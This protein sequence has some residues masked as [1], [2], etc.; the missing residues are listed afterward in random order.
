MAAW[1]RAHCLREWV[2]F[3]CKVVTD[4]VAEAR[5][6][7]KAARPDAGLGIY[8][9]PDVDGLSEPLTGQRLA[10]LAP[11]ADWLSPMLY[12]NILLRPPGWIGGALMPALSVVGG[13]TLPVV[14][15]DSNRDPTAVGDWGPEMSVDDWRA[16]LAEVAARSDTAGLVVFPGTSLIGNGRGEVLRAMLD[17]RR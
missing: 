6:R 3:K 15:A 7:L 9:V 11:L 10:D 2:D 4:F 1:I 8:V 12:H 5:A 13:K 14:Q 17:Q 16:T